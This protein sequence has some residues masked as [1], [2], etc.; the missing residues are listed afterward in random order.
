MNLCYHLKSVNSV[1]RVSGQ[2]DYHWVLTTETEIKVLINQWV[3]IGCC[4]KYKQ[5][6]FLFFVQVRYT[7]RHPIYVHCKMLIVDD[8]YIIVGSA[9]I[10]QRSL[11]KELFAYNV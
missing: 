7:M 9:N 4:S 6:S 11:G 10:N 5:I 1:K 2:E 3:K 8:D